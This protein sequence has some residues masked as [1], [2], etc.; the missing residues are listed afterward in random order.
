MAFF[1]PPGI[2]K[3]YSGEMM[4][5]PSAARMASANALTSAGNPV[6]FWISAL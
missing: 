1:S 3:L 6:V 4:I 2:E 5:T